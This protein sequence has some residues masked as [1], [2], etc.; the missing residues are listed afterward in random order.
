MMSSRDQLRSSAAPTITEG[1]PCGECADERIVMPLLRMRVLVVR[2]RE[3]LD[4]LAPLERLRELVGDAATVALCV[5]C[6]VLSVDLLA[7]HSD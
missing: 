2:R 5:Q 3:L 7:D 1:Y 4:L 6:Y